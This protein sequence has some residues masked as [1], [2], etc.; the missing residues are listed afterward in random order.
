MALGAVAACACSL[1]ATHKAPSLPPVRGQVEC[2][3]HYAYVTTDA[4]IGAAALVAGE[5]FMYRRL[6]SSGPGSTAPGAG[7]FILYIDA[8]ALAVAAA[9]GIA[10]LGSAGYGV[11][12]VQ[13]CR[14]MPAFQA[15]MRESGDPSLPGDHA[16]DVKQ[17]E[18]TAAAGLLLEHAR[19]AAARDDCATA[20][21][22]KPK[23]DELAPGAFSADAALAACETKHD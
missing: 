11:S 3:D 7:I 16:S 18:R 1:V 9:P 10:I 14:G 2:T 12:E 21:A 4:L 19:A 13:R 22:I 8:L 5:V 20:L 6:T 17:I 23:L 15:W